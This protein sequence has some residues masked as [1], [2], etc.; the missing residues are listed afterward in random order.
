MTR[1][2]AQRKSNEDYAYGR[3]SKE[4][5]DF[6]FEELGNVRIWLKE[7]KIHKLKEEY[8]RCKSDNGTAKQN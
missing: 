5:W 3:I 6:Q 2:D 1:Q 4:E 7:G 8:E